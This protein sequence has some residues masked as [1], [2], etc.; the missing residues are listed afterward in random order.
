MIIN[1]IGQSSLS[2]LQVSLSLIIWRQG[3]EVNQGEQPKDKILQDL[4]RFFF[5]FSPAGCHQNGKDPDP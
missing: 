5:R 4:V 1:S 2:T 3:E